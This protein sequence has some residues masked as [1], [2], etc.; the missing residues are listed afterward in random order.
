MKGHACLR[1]R[2]RVFDKSKTDRST[3]ADASIVI[4]EHAAK[5]QPVQGAQ[6]RVCTKRLQEAAEAREKQEDGCERG[7]GCGQTKQAERT[8]RCRVAWRPT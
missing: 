8:G 5:V 6:Q 3:R 7:E 1:V 4:D 2:G